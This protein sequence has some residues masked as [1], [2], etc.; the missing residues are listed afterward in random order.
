MYVAV[1]YLVL[2]VPTSPI[3]TLTGEGKVP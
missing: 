2:F 1:L 3:F